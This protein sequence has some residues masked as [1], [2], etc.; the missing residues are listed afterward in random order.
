[1]Q[2]LVFYAGI[3]LF[4]AGCALAPDSIGITVRTGNRTE[5]QGMNFTATYNN[6]YKPR[7]VVQENYIGLFGEPN[8]DAP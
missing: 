8:P 2:K 1:M 6:P 7:K 4:V 5:I 3:A